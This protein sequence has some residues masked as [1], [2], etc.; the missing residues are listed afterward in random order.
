MAKTVKE[1]ERVR[2][3]ASELEQLGVP[4]KAVDR[5]RQWA[6]KERKRLRDEA[7][8]WGKGNE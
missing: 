6:S 8:G 2:E 1:V 7:H 5:I 3:I 4:R